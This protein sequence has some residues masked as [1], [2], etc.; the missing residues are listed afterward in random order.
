MTKRFFSYDPLGTGME[1]HDTLEQARDSAEQGY[2]DGLDAEASTEELM[3]IIYG[4]IKGG[5][6]ELPGVTHDEYED[7]DDVSGWICEGTESPDSDDKVTP[8]RFG[9]FDAEESDG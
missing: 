7:M 4:E 6:T 1:L 8:L 3:P 2:D 9:D 5:A